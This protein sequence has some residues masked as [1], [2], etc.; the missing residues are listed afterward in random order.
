MGVTMNPLIPALLAIFLPLG[1]PDKINTDS[2]GINS[3]LENL[4]EAT[5]YIVGGQPTGPG[6][7]PWIC[8][9]GFLETKAW[10]H[11]CGGTLVTY[12]HVLTAA[13]CPVK[14]K[15][16]GR[17]NRI[18]VRCGDY[19]LQQQEDNEETQVRAVSQYDV[20]E[21]YRDGYLKFDISVLVVKQKF[22]LSSHIRPICLGSPSQKDANSAILV[23]GWG[24]DRHGVHGTNLK[25]AKLQIQ[26]SSFCKDAHTTLAP[27]FGAE[28]FC[29]ADQALAGS[30]SCHGDSGGPVFALR[31]T[32]HGGVSVYSNQFRYEL[33]G[34]VSGG[35]FPGECGGLHAPDIFTNTSHGPIYDWIV[36]KTEECN[37]KWWKCWWKCS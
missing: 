21:K 19:H 15:K 14:F 35:A 31:P 9:V 20:H 5:Q 25:I 13:H 23:V 26:S 37:R 34:L 10:E 7:W 17:D 27:W 33:Q 3:H 2:C 12:R 22:H 18:K 4:G 28:L 8:S 24:K 36:R 16:M 1:I 32:N 30:G 11:Q 6:S 29:A